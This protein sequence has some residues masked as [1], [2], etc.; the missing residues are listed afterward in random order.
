MIN[1]LLT[2]SKVSSLLYKSSKLA[3]VC[4]V[5]IL[6]ISAVNPVLEIYTLNLLIDR[7]LNLSSGIVL[8][9]GIYIVIALLLP[10]IIDLLYSLAYDIIQRRSQLTVVNKL[11]E[12]STETDLETLENPD[13][14][15]LFSRV[16]EL[17]SSPLTE[18]W[19]MQTNIFTSFFRIV[20]LITLVSTYFWGFPLMFLL[21]LI[22]DYWI[23]NKLVLKQH[24]LY[25]EQ[26]ERRRRYNYFFDLLTNKFHTREIRGF[27]AQA[28]LRDKWG[29]YKIEHD[30]TQTKFDLK[31]HAFQSAT[32]IASLLVETFSIFVM[33][34]WVIA[35]K[36][37]VA[38]FISSFYGLNH[39]RNTVTQFMHDIVNVKQHQLLS[40][41]L[42]QFLETTNNEKDRGGSRKLEVISEIE[43]D[44]VTYVYPGTDRRALNKVSF[45]IRKGERIAIVGENG[46]GKSTMARI[47]LGLCDPTSGT[48]RMDG[49]PKSEFDPVDQRLHTTAAFQ[50]YSKYYLTVRENVG[51]GQISFINDDA[52]LQLAATKSGAKDVIAKLP[53]EYEQQLGSIFEDG[54]ELSGGQ[55]Q[56]L[57]L[58]RSYIREFATLLVMDEPTAALDPIEE[59]NAYS[60]FLELAEGKTAIMIT[61]RLGAATLAD[62]V[63]VLKDG[64]LIESGSH[65]ML[66]E[67]K[68]YYF[69]LFSLQAEWYKY[70]GDDLIGTAKSQV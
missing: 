14:Q 9:A 3:F 27:S 44:E 8:L 32:T 7:G 63:F 53:N 47:L 51:L 15:S 12:K 19:S 66:M 49:I 57:A 46:A 70:E 13:H 25:L 58:A 41:H 36:T 62:R 2:Y 64:E 56:R 40:Q 60:Q 54:L 52:R 21:V 22:P 39:A 48:L 69:E 67:K 43:F 1:N 4:L 33:L 50:D 17:E 6:V 68:G 30:R 37:T 18:Y 10:I 23:R 20:S 26:S 29:R 55:W 34:I 61:H 5:F 28:F 24:N 45:A 65:Q 35:G 42:I 59:L 11:M 38:T 16:R 31:Y